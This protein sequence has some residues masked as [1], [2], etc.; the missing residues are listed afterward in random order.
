M[1]KFIKTFLAA[2]LML[3]SVSMFASEAPPLKKAKKSIEIPK[4]FEQFTQLPPELQTQIILTINEG[5]TPLEVVKRL[6]QLRR[7]DRRMKDVIESPFYGKILMQK[8]ADRFSDDE[9][10]HPYEKKWSTIYA[11]LVLATSGSL[12]WLK[13][14]L[15]HRLVN[16][17][18]FD[19]YLKE[20]ISAKR[21]NAQ[22]LI[23]LTDDPNYILEPNQDTLLSI[24]VFTDQKTLID[25]LIKMG[26]D[27]GFTITDDN[28]YRFNPLNTFPNM[29]T[30]GYMYLYNKALINID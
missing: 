6:G 25:D 16:K 9:E 26:A 29:G 20:N 11:A 4:T 8:I 21:L 19:R 10:Q 18:T 2:S 30:P 13:E 22:Q 5:T 3:V 24:A 15:N 17:Y 27:P 28:G 12:A 7:V 1:K 23:E 14:E